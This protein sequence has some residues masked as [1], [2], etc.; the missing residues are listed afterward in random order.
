MT[1]VLIIEDDRDIR[2]T[3]AD[4]FAVEGYDVARASNGAEG[5]EQARRLH[6]DVIVLDLMM[7]VMDGW[8]FRA[9]QK[10]DPAIADVPVVV[11]SAFG[12]LPDMDVAAFIPKPCDLD[13]LLE[14]THRVERS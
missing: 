1:R 9:E 2:D 10:R 4:V 13:V 6:P 12:N 7:P 11:V 5:L 14:T 8:Q 3:L